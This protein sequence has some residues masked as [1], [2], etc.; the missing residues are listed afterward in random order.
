MANL[1]NSQNLIQI[2]RR[3]SQ[4]WRS[5]IISQ[6]ARKEIQQCDRMPFFAS[7]I[8]WLVEKISICLPNIMLCRL[9][10]KLLPQLVD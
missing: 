7:N 9:Q 10:Y 2:F 3:A 1:L 8:L 4:L 6:N 5:S